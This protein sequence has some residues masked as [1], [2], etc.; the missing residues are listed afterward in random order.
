MQAIIDTKLNILQPGRLLPVVSDCFPTSTLSLIFVSSGSPDNFNSWAHS[1]TI[2]SS[3]WDL[4]SEYPVS[5]A[6]SQIALIS[7]GNPAEK[8]WI[9]FMAFELNISLSDPATLRRWFIYSWVSESFKGSRWYRIPILCLNAL[10]R[11]SSIIG[12]NSFWPTM[13]ILISFVSANSI[14][15]NSRI[16]S[17]SSLEMFWASSTINSMVLFWRYVLCK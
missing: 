2:L 3:I 11:F 9:S 4:P 5:R 14:F 12:S 15:D 7:R 10:F 16:Y 6:R 8:K 13:K 17:N 1:L